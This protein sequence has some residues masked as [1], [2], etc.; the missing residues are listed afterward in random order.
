MKDMDF[1]TIFQEV[2]PKVINEYLRPLT[3]SRS[4][5]TYR[6]L[7]REDVL[8]MLSFFCLEACIDRYDG[9]EEIQPDPTLLA[10]KT[11]LMLQRSGLLQAPV[12]F[13]KNWFR[14]QL[15]NSA[16][17]I[18]KRERRLRFRLESY[19]QEAVFPYSPQDFVDFLGRFD[20]AAPALEELVDPMIAE[21]QAI[22]RREKKR[23]MADKIKKTMT[24]SLI[25]QF[26]EPLGLQVNY[27][28]T[29]GNYVHLSI[30]QTKETELDIALDKLSEVLSDTE[31]L[32]QSMKVVPPQKES[33]KPKRLR[34]IPPSILF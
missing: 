31:S 3:C 6:T 26:L 13:R 34:V 17:R 25:K 22:R 7:D 16:Y 9:S 30:R 32:L 10:E 14:V 2:V 27:R 29:S 21:M 19:Y 4:G 5:N 33:E 11:V 24:E 28:L 20:E 12:K 1:K 15:S 18:S 23:E 8:H